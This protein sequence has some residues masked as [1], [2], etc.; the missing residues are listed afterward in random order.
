MAEEFKKGKKLKIAVKYQI[1]KRIMKESVKEKAHQKE[2]YCYHRLIASF[3]SKIIRKE[4]RRIKKKV[5]SGKC[6]SNGFTKKLQYIM[7]E[8][9]LTESTKD[10]FLLS[11][12][13]Y[14]NLPSIFNP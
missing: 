14:Q 3:M 13:M 7:H 8:N 1:A 5:I 12:L 6:L 4:F 11:S 9:E 10:T 2:I